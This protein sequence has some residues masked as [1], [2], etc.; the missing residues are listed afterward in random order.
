MSGSRMRFLVLG[1]ID[2]DVEALEGALQ[3]RVAPVDAVA[4]VGDLGA[5]WSK[6]AT[7]RA[8]FRRLGGAGLP[9]FWVPG[10]TDAPLAEYLSESANVEV[11]YPL[12]HGV[13]GTVAS[14]SNQVLV[15]GMGG[16]VED[17]PKTIRIE[18]ALLRYPAW[19]VEYRLK[20][21]WE[22]DHPWC[23]LL[24]TTA[25]AHKGRGE[26]GSEVLAELIKTHNARLV[27]IPGEQST[28][29]LGKTLVVRPG[30]AHRGEFAVADLHEQSVEFAT[31][32]P[33]ATT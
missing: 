30:R 21:L 31:V 11:A 33:V 28:E 7:Y 8:V 6:P 14:A 27:V 22:F 1:Q 32:A 16:A 17:D 23:V 4:V 20:V 5:P 18:E 2:G 9:T 25:P 19:E 12:T 10:E 29:L 26:A 13:H 3:Q 24:F 15:A